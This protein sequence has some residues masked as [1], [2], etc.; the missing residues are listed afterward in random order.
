VH[1]A[2]GETLQVE[3]PLPVE[4]RGFIEQLKNPSRE[5]L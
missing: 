3:A 5:T 4:C 2:T 1:P